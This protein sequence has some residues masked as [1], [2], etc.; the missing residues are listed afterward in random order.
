M[1]ASS[2]PG[3][4]HSHSPLQSSVRAKLPDHFLCPLVHYVAAA[5]T[6]GLVLPAAALPAAV[7]IVFFMFLGCSSRR[8]KSRSRIALTHRSQYAAANMLPCRCSCHT[9]TCSVFSFLRK[10]CVLP[11]P[12]VAGRGL[13]RHHP[14]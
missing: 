5:A 14:L 8:H 2:I 13:D 9:H 6:P 1:G 11:P 7:I 3:L 4:K 12:L 10:E